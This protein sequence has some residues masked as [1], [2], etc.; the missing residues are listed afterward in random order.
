M[1]TCIHIILLILGVLVVILA[2]VTPKLEDKHCK[3]CPTKAYC[4]LCSRYPSN[5]GVFY[6]FSWLKEKYYGNN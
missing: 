4:V 1:I 5:R 6:I 3:K 2:F